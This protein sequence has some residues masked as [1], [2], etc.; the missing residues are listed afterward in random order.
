M[1]TT[2]EG[3]CVCAG[4]E[5]LK[6]TGD[7][8]GKAVV[9]NVVR[10]IDSGERPSTDANASLSFLSRLSGFNPP[11]REYIRKFAGLKLDGRC[12]Q[13]GQ[14]WSAERNLLKSKRADRCARPQLLRSRS[15]TRRVTNTPITYLAKLDDLRQFWVLVSSPFREIRPQR[16]RIKMSRQNPVAA[17]I[18]DEKFQRISHENFTLEQFFF[19]HLSKLT[20]PMSFLF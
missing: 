3:R 18:F 9:D 5:K 10:I 14:R 16:K 4:S 12:K 11:S 15:I 17:E 7:G 6:S 2:I 1:M 20:E 8:R 19:R 13:R